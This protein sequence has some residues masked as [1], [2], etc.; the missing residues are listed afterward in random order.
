MMKLMD[1]REL[2]ICKIPEY[3]SI[4]S[5]NNISEISILVNTTGTNVIENNPNNK[6]K[7]DNIFVINKTYKM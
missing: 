5:L 6:Y 1:I 4:S 2:N 3:P 7:I